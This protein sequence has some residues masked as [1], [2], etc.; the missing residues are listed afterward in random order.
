MKNIFYRSPIIC[1]LLV[2]QILLFPVKGESAPADTIIQNLVFYDSE[3]ATDKSLVLITVLDLKRSPI[4]NCRIWL[5]TDKTNPVYKAMTNSN[6]EACFLIPNNADYS[7]DV[8]SMKNM[9]TLKIPGYPNMRRKL[10]IMVKRDDLKKGKPVIDESEIT[11]DINK[12]DYKMPW[13][14]VYQ[15]LPVN[16][17]SDDKNAIVRIIVSDGKGKRHAR[18]QVSLS[19]NSTNKVYLTKTDGVG[20]ASFFVPNG[21]LYII[22]IANTPDYS[23]ITIP[24]IPGVNG[25]KQLIYV[26][27]AVK[28]TEKNDTITQEI[29]QNISTA[30]RMFVE[31]SIRSLEKKP[32]P[33][34]PFYLRAKHAKKVYAAVTDSHGKACLL[35]P[36]GDIYYVDFFYEKGADSLI[37]QN[38]DSYRHVKIEYRYLG[39]KEIERRKAE[40]KRKLELRDSLAKITEKK[41]EEYYLKMRIKDSLRD[42][43]AVEQ[44]FIGQLRLKTDKETIKKRLEAR[45]IKER[46]KVEEDPKY[47]EKAQY[48]VLAVFNRLKMKWKDKII[49]TDLTGSMYPYWDQILV[50]HS[51]RLMNEEQK[52]Y[53]FFNDGDDKADDEKVIGATG[54]IYHTPKKNIDALLETMFETAKA[55][56]GGDGPEN[57]IEALLEAQK[58][59]KRR[60]TEVILIADNYSDIK[61]LVLLEKLHVPVRIVLCGVN[62]N[63]NEQYLELAYKTKGSVHTIEKDIYDL[64]NLVDGKTIEIGG[65][66]YKVLRGKFIKVTSI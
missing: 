5:R 22:G 52:E 63:V 2:L 60:I 11:G 41:W 17:K 45:A 38:D 54:G 3:P 33:D 36:K 10:K 51:M 9:R 1:F 46:E 26:K 43:P 42:L 34:E 57:D 49:V 15:N 12:Q 47:F 31:A 40:R 19:D 7:V 28:E 61:D 50:W 21:R 20:V 64:A 32:L 39:T 29:L 66:K 6:G 44:N 4:N 16:K 23:E 14:T 13:D 8:E 27:D 58:L 53:I 48:E 35:V 24:N 56:S 55:G 18:L 59:K 37:A 25:E 65:T 30:K 62:L